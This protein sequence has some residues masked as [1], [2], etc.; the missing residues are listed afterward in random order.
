MEAE[1]YLN[2]YNPET[3]KE[4][5]NSKESTDCKKSMNSLS[6]NHTWKLSDLPVG[7]KATTLLKTVFRKTGTVGY[8]ITYR[9]TET[10]GVLHCYSDS[11]FGGCTKASQ[12]TSGYVMIYA[13]GAISWRS[14]KQVIVATSTNEAEIIAASDA[15]K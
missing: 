12:S 7:A 1:S 14:Q 15:A 13:G 4:A 6:E 3:Y 11:D 2:D 10:K 8:G 9:A 5:V